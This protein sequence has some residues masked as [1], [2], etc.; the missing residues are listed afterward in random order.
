MRN[1]LY[2]SN[3]K[4]GSNKPGIMNRWNNRAQPHIIYTSI[5]Y[6]IHTASAPDYYMV[7]LSRARRVLTRLVCMSVAYSAVVLS[8]ISSIRD[9]L[10]RSDSG[11]CDDKIFSKCKT[12]YQNLTVYQPILQSI[13]Q[14]NQNTRCREKISLT[15]AA[16][17][18][19][20][21]RLSDKYE[22]EDTDSPEGNICE[23]C[24]GTS[25][26]AG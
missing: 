15:D 2:Y 8:T 16:L 20:I 13:T 3:K 24:R 9:A 25:G 4:K 23:V 12:S 11:I 7:G 18:C 5:Q 1:S 22:F 17:L 19:A 14:N 21:E 26:S 6:I 10:A